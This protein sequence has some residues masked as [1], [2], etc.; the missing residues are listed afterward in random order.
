VNSLTA[1][2]EVLLWAPLN[3]ILLN[4]IIT[5]EAHTGMNSTLNTLPVE[6]HMGV[7]ATPWL[8]MNIL[9]SG[10]LNRQETLLLPWVD[11]KLA[12]KTSPSISSLNSEKEKEQENRKI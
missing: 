11:L 8:S 7:A 2:T 3:K 4:S 1:T 5:G 12:L 6:I 10:I 9:E